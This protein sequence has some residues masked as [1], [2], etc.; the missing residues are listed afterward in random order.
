MAEAVLHY[1]YDPLCGWCYGAAPLV[2]AARRVP[3]LRLAL[4]G[5]GMLSGSN[6]R[7]ITADWRSHVLPHDLRIAQMTGQPF[8]DAYRDGL[9]NDKGAVLDSSPPITAV[10][11]AEAIDGQGAAMLHALQHA[12]YVD[13][14]RIAEL[15]VL[16][17]LASQLG[18]DQAT[19]ASKY[20]QL[21]G[22]ATARHIA[23][24]RALLA[25]VGGHGFPTFALD[26]GSGKLVQI[27]AGSYLGQPDRLA[28]MLGSAC[29]A[30]GC[31]L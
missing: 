13:G 21:A 22:E 15:P 5:G 19:F 26:D 7:H 14:L 12:H 28:A 23:D 31:S 4:H 29:D 11:A 3:G 10:L 16:L 27:D 17:A 9:L 20:D 30:T 25:Q 18:L 2:E 24:S 8:G 1:I 6:R